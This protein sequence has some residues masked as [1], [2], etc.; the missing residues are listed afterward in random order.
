MEC[1]TFKNLYYCTRCSLRTEVLYNEHEYK[2]SDAVME[3]GFYT[4]YKI[5]EGYCYEEWT[6]LESLGHM[7]VSTLSETFFRACDG[8]QHFIR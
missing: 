2:Y 8:T 5:G 1:E 7:W 6:Q 4:E 3:F